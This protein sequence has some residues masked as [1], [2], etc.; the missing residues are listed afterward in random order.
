[1]SFLQVEP[2]AGGGGGMGGEGQNKCLQIFCLAT[3][4]MKFSL[5]VTKVD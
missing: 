5:M 1:M 2:G 3:V 4:G